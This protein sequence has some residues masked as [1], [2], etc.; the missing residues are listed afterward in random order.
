MANPYLLFDNL[1]DRASTYSATSEVSGFPVANLADW[2]Q[3]TGYRWK[4]DG[5]AADQNIDIDLGADPDNVADAIAIGG[6]NLG[7]VGATVEVLEGGSSPATTSRLGATAITTDLPLLLLVPNT[8]GSRYWRVQFASMSA[9]PQIGILTLG[10]ALEI[11]TGVRASL[12]PYGRAAAVEESRSNSNGSPIGVNVLHTDKSF[13]L[14][15]GDIGLTDSEFYQPSSG[16]GFDADFMPHAIDA[17]KP[18][19]FAW[20]ITKEPTDHVWLCTTR[21]VRMPFIAHNTRRALHLDANAWR[22]A[23]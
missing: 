10:R 15:Y 9:A 6:H 20:N 12:D 21:S 22:E 4:S 5:G 18:Y 16:V 7:T 19:W 3:G 13:S 1:L 8:V 2:R 11:P 17:A 14:S 23:T